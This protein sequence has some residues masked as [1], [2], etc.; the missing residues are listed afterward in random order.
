MEYCRVDHIRNTSKY[1]SAL[2][3]WVSREL[4]SLSRWVRLVLGHDSDGAC[5][6]PGVENSTDEMSVK[7]DKMLSV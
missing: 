3:L 6:H 4:D 2:A 1:V 7:P 5:L